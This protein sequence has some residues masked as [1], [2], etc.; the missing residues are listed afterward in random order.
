[1]TNIAQALSDL[2]YILRS[3]GAAG[4]DQAFEAGAGLKKKIYTAH[5][6]SR[7]AELIAKEYHPCWSSL[8]KFARKLHGRN[9]Y[10][11]LGDNLR[12]P[13]KFLICWT[14]D[15]CKSHLTR[16]ILTGGTGTAISIAERC[17]IPIYNMYLEEDLAKIWEL[18]N[19]PID[20][21]TEI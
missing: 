2:G 3:G 14:P 21:L 5:N 19:K 12:T 7:E 16:S 1:M 20:N 17:F 4:A 9:S 18:C 13:S 15:G 6:S 10:Q 8:T 11:V